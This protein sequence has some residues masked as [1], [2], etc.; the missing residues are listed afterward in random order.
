MREAP[1]PAASRNAIEDYAIIGD[2]RS[3]ALISREG[4]IDWLCW[5]RFDSPSLFAAILDQDKGGRFSVRPVAP[6]RITRRYLG[7]TNVLETTFVTDGGVLRLT[8]LMPVTSEADKRRSMWASHQILRRVECIEGAV[9]IEIRCDPRPSYGRESCRLKDRGAL[10]LYFEK[11]GRAFVL[12][13]E[14]PLRLSRTEEGVRQRHRLQAGDRHHLSAVYSEREPSFVPPLGEEAERRIG[15]T[16]DWWRA[17]SA[18]CTYEGPHRDAV[19]R[20]ALVLKLLAYAPSGAIIAAPTTSLPEWRGGTRNWDYR[21]CWLR[22]ASLTL[23]ALFDLGFPEEALAFLHWLTHSTRLTWPDLQILYDVHGETELAEEEL[24]ALSGFADSRPVRIGNQASDQFQLD[25]YGEVIDAAYAFVR[26]GGR[27]TAATARLLVGFGKTVCR[28]WREPDEGIWEVRA[29]RRHH[30][31]SKAMCWVALDRLLRLHQA[32][33]LRA[34]V[35]WFERERDALRAEIDARGFNQR[36]GSYVSVYEGDEL[37]ASLLLLARHGFIEPH[38]QRARGTR[39]AIIEA[40]GSNGLLYRYLGIDDGL[41]GDEGAFGI[42]SFWAV[43]AYALAGELQAGEALFERVLGYANDL[44]LFAEEID[45]ADGSALGNFPQA[46]THVG[47]IDAALSL[48][49][50]RRDNGEHH[51]TRASG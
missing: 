37:D 49:G 12:R 28:R 46:F 44:G 10:G 22:D 3:A 32:G 36:L 5:P 17:W 27:L 23:R 41:P 6:A 13:S 26:Q 14:I 9:D 50:A 48:A 42:C 8:D 47:L 24:T 1:T 2:C 7:E 20:S 43:D 19:V 29:G 38:S 11:Q 31:Y 21:F 30:T 33:K 16:L 18:R 4:S 35:E 39:D 51:Q 34:P 25:I 40:L 45:P 15:L